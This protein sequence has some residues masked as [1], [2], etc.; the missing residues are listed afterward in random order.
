MAVSKPAANQTMAVSKLAKNRIIAG[1]DLATDL[2]TTPKDFPPSLNPRSHPY[3]D[4]S[5]TPLYLEQQKDIAL[6]L[7]QCTMTSTMST[8]ST[9]IASNISQLSTLTSNFLEPTHFI[10]TS[11]S[12]NDIINKI[13]DSFQEESS[14]IFWEQEIALR[15]KGNDKMMWDTHQSQIIDD[16]F[17][18]NEKSLDI[19]SSNFDLSTTVSQ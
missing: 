11:I 9:T 10:L 15:E 5:H 2:S 19:F 3:N 18:E 6:S 7:N 17:Y 12:D 4:L 13:T 14:N 1:S 16:E 8:G